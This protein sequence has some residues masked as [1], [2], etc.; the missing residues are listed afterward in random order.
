MIFNN[1]SSS[2]SASVDTEPRFV[3]WT[4]FKTRV[5][6]ES[7]TSVALCYISY[8]LYSREKL[9]LQICYFFE[10]TEWKKYFG[11]IVRDFI[12]QCALYV[13]ILQSWDPGELKQRQSPL[14]S[15]LKY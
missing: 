14:K 3:S 15:T 5:S 12:M 8:S 4:S 2:I 6:H 11:S 9:T 10:I 13:D 1:S 7:E